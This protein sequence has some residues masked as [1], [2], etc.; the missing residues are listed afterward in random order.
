VITVQSQAG[1]N[2]Q[3][4]SKHKRGNFGT[5]L[6]WSNKPEIYKT[7]P[8]KK[9]IQ[10]PLPSQEQTLPFLEILK[11]RKSIRSYSP[12]PLKISN[13]SFLLWAST[14][15]QR[16]QRG[17]EFRTAP[18]AGALYPIETYLVAN[19]VEGLEKGLYHYNIAA[20][21]LEELKIGANGEELAQAALDQEM[22]AEA[23]VVFVWSAIFNRSKWKYKQR[24]Y[25]YVYLE[26]GHIVENLALS[27]TSVGLG[28]CQI[29]AF[30]D[31]EVNRIIEIDGTE[32]SVIY[33][34]TAGHPEKV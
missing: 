34:S 18:S 32:E 12:E 24:A 20:H 7:Y 29:G 27:A 11:K 33:L 22:C 16:T 28:T 17:H 31:D 4:E 8:S 10:L 23:P 15:I 19:N 26:A 1:D 30:L 9:Q 25:R 14:G 5:P 13:L 2:F 3:K 6:D 21:T